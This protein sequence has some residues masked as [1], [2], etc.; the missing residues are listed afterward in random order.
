[1]NVLVGQLFFFWGGG[2][3]R[4][5]YFNTVSDLTIQINDF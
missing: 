3:V 4:F 1:M 2:G 5:K